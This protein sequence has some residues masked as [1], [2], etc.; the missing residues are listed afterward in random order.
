MAAQE[1]EVLEE[2]VLRILIATDNHLGFMVWFSIS[3]SRHVY[4]LLMRD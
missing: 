1:E 2:N 4:K 3:S